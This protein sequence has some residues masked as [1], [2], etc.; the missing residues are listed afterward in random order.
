MHTCDSKNFEKNTNSTSYDDKTT[1][2]EGIKSGQGSCGCGCG[3]KPKIVEEDIIETEE[4][5]WDY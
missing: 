2:Y 3:A 4:T 5:K 1:S